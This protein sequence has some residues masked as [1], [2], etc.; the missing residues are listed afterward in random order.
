VPTVATSSFWEAA[1]YVGHLIYD[2]GMGFISFGS[3]VVLFASVIGLAVWILVEI[4]RRD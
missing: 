2:V 3:V 1:G 4:A